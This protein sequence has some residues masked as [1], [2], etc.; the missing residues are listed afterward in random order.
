M[1]WT[2][3]EGTKVTR[4]WVHVE[5][6]NYLWTSGADVQATWKRYGWTPPSLTMEP[7]PPEKEIKP[8]KVVGGKR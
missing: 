2:P 3:P 5:H 7:P 1:N 8:L 6:K 4:P